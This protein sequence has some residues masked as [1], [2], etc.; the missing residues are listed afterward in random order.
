MTRSRRRSRSRQRHAFTLVEVLLVLVILVVIASVT[1]IAIG[2][3]RERAF[4][5]TARTQINALSTPLDL[6]RL[7]VGD[8][9]STAQGLESLRIAPSDIADPADWGG[10][11]LR[12]NIPMDPWRNPYQYAHPGNYNTEMPDIWSWGPDGISDTEDDVVNW[13]E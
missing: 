5:N 9:P 4:I 2:P 13:E 3:A 8:F 10:P 12:K 1:V 7:D 6:F 11:Y